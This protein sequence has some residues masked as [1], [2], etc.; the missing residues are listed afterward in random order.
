MISWRTMSQV[1]VIIGSPRK[2]GNSYKI[3]K[4]IEKRMRTLGDIEFNYFFLRD[5]HLELCRGC[6][7]CLSI[8][9]DRCPL[10]DDR[11]DIEKQMID[12]DG[13]IF[14][15]PV[16]SLNVTAL[17]KNLLDRFA[18]TLHRPRFFRQKVMIVCTTGALGLKETIDRLSV[19][20]YAGFNLVHTAGFYTPESNVALKSKNRIDK[21][22][23]LAARKF[24]EALQA[25]QPPSPRLISLIAFRA[26]QAAFATAH[27]YNLSECDYTYFKENGWFE[28]GR[29]YYTDAKINPVKNMIAVLVGKIVRRNTL[30]EFQGVPWN[31]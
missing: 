6:W 13:V 25:K 8:G 5:S 30:K 10:K 15:S 7:L 24:F 4:R 29:Q 19:I 28:K 21:D 27:E 14:V 2:M 23:N 16:Y 26:Q 12:A 22:I 31:S 9:D 11:K 17:M 1:L 20:R 18:Y 3:V